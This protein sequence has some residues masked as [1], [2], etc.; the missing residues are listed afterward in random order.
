MIAEA[1]FLYRLAWLLTKIRALEGFGE[2][3]LYGD[4][5]KMR[6]DLY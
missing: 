4:D 2:A 3:G 1:G 5:E 6:M